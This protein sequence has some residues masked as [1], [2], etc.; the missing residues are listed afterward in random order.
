MHRQREIRDQ[1]LGYFEKYGLS[2]EKQTAAMN[3]STETIEKLISKLDKLGE[4]HE[5]A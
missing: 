2:L 5:A 4:T 1:L 3:V